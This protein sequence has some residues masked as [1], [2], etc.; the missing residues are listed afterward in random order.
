MLSSKVKIVVALC[1]TFLLAEWTYAQ[2][3]LNLYGIEVTTDNH[4]IIKNLDPATG[5]LTTSF[6]SKMEVGSITRGSHIVMNDVYYLVDQSNTLF[7]FDI[8]Q[9]KLIS[10]ELLLAK[11]LR[12]MEASSCDSTLFGMSYQSIRGPAFLNAY[13]PQTN[14]LMQVTA[15][16]ALLDIALD[17]N[18]IHTKL[19][20]SYILI[21]NG[22]LYEIDIYSGSI[23]NQ[24]SVAN[25]NLVSCVADPASGL[26]YGIEIIPNGFTLKSLNPKTSEIDIVGTTV[27]NYQAIAK[28]M[29]AISDGHYYLNLNLAYYKLDLTDGKIIEELPIYLDIFKNVE[30]NNTCSRLIQSVEVDDTS[31]GQD[32]GSINITPND[33]SITYEYSW[34]TDLEGFTTD[35]TKTNDLAPGE[36]QLQ[37][38]S[39]DGSCIDTATVYIGESEEL[40]Y[41]IETKN[42]G[43]EGIPNGEINIE[44]VGRT[45]NYQYSIDNGE[46]FQSSNVFTDLGEG[47]YHIVIQGNRNCKANDLIS[48][49]EPDEYQISIV[50][51]I[52]IALG[53]EVM[54]EPIISNTHPAIELT[55]ISEHPKYYISCTECAN[56]IVKPFENTMYYLNILDT[57]SGC[58]ATD[59]VSL[60]VRKNN[61]DVY[62][63]NIFSPNGDEYNDEFTVFGTDVRSIESLT[64]YDRWGSPVLAKEN[65]QPDDPEAIWDGTKRGQT[66]EPGNYSYAIQ[67]TYL[68]GVKKVFTGQVFLAK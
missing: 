7:A 10:Q 14:Q 46:S 31:C 43:C 37:M 50:D 6:D 61:R 48:I 27:K 20:D 35:E 65:L 47:L 19:G 21:S 28:S 42:L 64:I 8:K 57:N 13:N 17:Q 66:L 62:I 59:S 4:L 24:F 53:E 40:E 54:L 44:V 55:W 23:K 41:K 3:D 11:S 63:P 29:H 15:P 49:E 67:L 16:D 52:E 39:P 25:Q 68:D 38:T 26:L 58:T 36:Y 33:P 32:N 2:C 22:E 30:F 1:S 5:S 9:G 51:T 45:V 18:S 12:F 60:L 56:P 34:K